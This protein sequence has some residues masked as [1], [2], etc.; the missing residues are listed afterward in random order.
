MSAP[1]PTDPPPRRRLRPP[2]FWLLLALATVAYTAFL[3]ATLLATAG[4]APPSVWWRSLASPE[5]RHAIT[6]SLATSSLSAVICLVISVPIGY[7][8]ARSRFPGKS[9]L[10]ALLDVP[11]FLPPMVMGLCLLIFF[12]TNLG[13][14]I[15]RGMRFTY[16]S[17]GVVLAQVLISAAFSIRTLRGTFEHLSARPEAV[18]CSL[19]CTPGQAFVLVGLPA[20]RRGL[21]AAT[22]IAWARSFGE[23]GPVLVFAGATRMRTEVLPTTVWLELSVGNLEA[24]VTVSLLMIVIAVA[25][26]VVFRRFGEKETA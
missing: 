24:A 25:V 4:F 23:F 21:I 2:F 5:I 8:L 6:L 11:I 7:L 15:E 16:T 9:L 1:A 12:Q 19:G 20:A 14:F 18:A 10:E 22:S 17:A 3:L 26:L 13:H